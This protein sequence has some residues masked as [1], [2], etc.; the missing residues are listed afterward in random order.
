MTQLT[1]D[2]VMRHDVPTCTLLDT[3]LVAA[4]RMREHNTNAVAILDSDGY[5]V[6]IFTQSDALRVWSKTSSRAQYLATKVRDHMTGNVTTC[7]RT[8]SVDQVIKIFAGKSFHHLVV[9]DDQSK[10]RAKPVGLLISGEVMQALFSE[11][12]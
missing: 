4:S 12:L 9:V 10:R 5:L 2:D 6:G 11:N 3:L 1:A 7:L 8:T